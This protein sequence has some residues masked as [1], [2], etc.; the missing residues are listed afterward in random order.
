[1]IEY[2][3]QS[4]PPGLPGRLDPQISA[5]LGPAMSQ[6]GMGQSFKLVAEQ[7]AD[8]ASR[9]LLLQEPEPQAGT[10][11]RAG[12]LPAFEAMARPAPAIAPF[13]STTLRWPGEIV[14]PLRT[15]ISRAS[16]VAAS[17]AA[18]PQPGC[19]AP[20]VPPRVPPHACAVSAPAGAGSAAL[21]PRPVPPPL[22]SAAPAPPVRPGAGQSPRCSRQQATTAPPAPG[23][24]RPASPSG[25]AAPARPVQRHSPSTRTADPW[26]VLLACSSAEPALVR[27]HL[28]GCLGSVAC[29]SP[30]C[31][32]PALLPVDGAAQGA[33]FCHRGRLALVPGHDVHLVDLHLTFQRRR[34]DPG[35][36]PVA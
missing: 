21:P 15:S 20:P 5:A 11:D 25:S 18:L 7:E 8:V 13:R 26:T 22:A 17:R 24:P 27:V 36:Q 10:V 3:Q 9:G 30:A 31:R 16:R 35:R 14:S 29:P 28:K 1:M 12:V 6:I 33:P 4:P 32:G 34:R 2:A 19:S 23:P